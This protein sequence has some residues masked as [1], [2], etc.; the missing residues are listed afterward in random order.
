M[1]FQV[2]RLAELSFRD[3]EFSFSFRGINDNGR[4]IRPYL[5]TAVSIVEAGFVN[6]P[7]LSFRKSVMFPINNLPQ[8]SIRRPGA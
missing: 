6:G 4:R 3:A 1:F 5:K 7:L 8:P 2:F